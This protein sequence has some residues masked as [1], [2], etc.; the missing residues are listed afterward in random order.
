V[1]AE[2]QTILSPI[3]RFKAVY[4]YFQLLALKPQASQ[5]FADER[6]RQAECSNCDATMIPKELLPVSNSLYLHL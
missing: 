5:W 4:I 3:F 6:F 1:D 2:G